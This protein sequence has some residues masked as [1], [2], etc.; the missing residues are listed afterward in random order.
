MLDANNVVPVLADLQEIN[1]QTYCYKATIHHGPSHQRKTIEYYPS[2]LAW[3]LD[4]L[5]QEVASQYNNPIVTV[6]EVKSIPSK[7]HDKLT[8]K[9]RNQIASGEALLKIMANIECEA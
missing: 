3:D 4:D 9:A 6:V 1:M 8:T 2:L 7:E 5:A